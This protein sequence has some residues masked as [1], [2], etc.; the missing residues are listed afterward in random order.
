MSDRIKG[1]VVIQ[2]RVVA[3]MDDNAALMRRTDHVLGNVGTL[4][5]LAQVDVNWMSSKITLLAE[6]VDLD[7]PQGL[8]HVGCVE[9]NQVT[10]VQ[11]V[12]TILLSGELDPAASKSM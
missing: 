5:I 3:A 1:D 6:S 12:G 7:T 10:S 2:S 8:R 9:D 4:D 11:E